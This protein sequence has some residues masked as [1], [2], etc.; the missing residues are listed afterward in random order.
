MKAK[1]I[2]TGFG[3]I[4]ITACTPNQVEVEDPKIEEVVADTLVEIIIDTSV[5]Q[6]LRSHGLVDILS[7]D[8]T[9]IVD[10]KYAT[11]DNFMGFVL[12][13]TLNAVYLQEDVAVKLAA[14]Q[15]F[16]KDTLPTHSLLVYDGVRPVDV[17]QQMWEAL[18]SIP[19]TERG[20]FV[21]NPWYGSVHNYGA[22]VDI[23]ICDESGVPL[24]MGAGYDDFRDIAF[25]SKEWKFL[26]SGE[27]SAEQYGNRKLL[28]AVMKSQSFRNI[29]SEWWHFNACSRDQ[30]VFKYKK[31]MYESGV[32]E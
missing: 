23:T 16:L 13:D 1:L 11:S 8:S 14:C 9:L 32:R 7:I 27:L 31:L 17:Q 10:L 4:L 24:D 3:L 6:S 25:P 22:A 20:K 18:D 30:A 2:I 12:Y 29:P 21:S 28:R 15:A 26:N 5:Q 19:T